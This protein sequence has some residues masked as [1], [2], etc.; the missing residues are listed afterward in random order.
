M[1]EWA[2]RGPEKGSSRS[3]NRCFPKYNSALRVGLSS[4]SLSKVQVTALGHR[5]VAAL[6]QSRLS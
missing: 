4:Y 1:V 5:N 6:P 3:Q 2:D